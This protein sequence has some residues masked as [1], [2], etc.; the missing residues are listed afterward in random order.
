MSTSEVEEIISKTIIQLQKQEGAVQFKKP[1]T[2]QGWVY[3]TLGVAT[4]V[5]FCWTSIV[6][7]NDIARHQ[8][9]DY[10]AGTVEI[11]EQIQSNHAE[12]I[13]DNAQ[14]QTDVDIELKIIKEVSPIREDL[15]SIKQNVKGV[16]QNVRDV[17]QD[18]RDVQRTLQT[19]S[20]R[21]N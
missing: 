14:H 13:D 7:L 8:E 12:H 2:F 11:M 21:L 9:E 16:E 17:Q 20:D 6:F 10:H 19:I 15:T 1:K 4:I 3:I 18:I 5:G